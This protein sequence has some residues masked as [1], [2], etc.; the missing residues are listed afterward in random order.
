MRFG[1]I[2]RRHPVRATDCVNRAAAFR[3]EREERPPGEHST[4][5][6]PL[7]A[8]ELSRDAKL[9]PAMRS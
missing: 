6:P 7:R 5:P 1:V 8:A 9:E 4:Q 2:R 3:E